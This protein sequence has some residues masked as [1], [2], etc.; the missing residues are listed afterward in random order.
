RRDGRA[1]A[2]P[3]GILAGSVPWPFFSA[4]AISSFYTVA[5]APWLMLCLAY[6]MSVLIGS[7]AADRERRLAG[8]LFVGSLLVLIVLVSA[9]FWPVSTGQV[10]DIEQWRYRMWLPSWT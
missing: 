3:S 7:A 8:G 6:V 10:L 1:C 5:F 9:F 4:R 2:A